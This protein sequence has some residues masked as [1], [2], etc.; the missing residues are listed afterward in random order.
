[1]KKA[2][3]TGRQIVAAIF[4]GIFGHVLFAIGWIGLGLLILGSIL[5]AVLGGSIEALLGSFLDP[6]TIGETFNSAGGV[7]SS[8]AIGL[9]IGAGVFILLGFFV[10]ALILRGG[11]VRRPW[12][13]TLSAILIAAIID[14]PLLFVYASI[15]SGQDSP[16]FLV[17]TVLGTIIVGILVWLW[18]TW[19]HRGP[20][21]EFAG[22][23]VTGTASA[24]PVE[25]GATP[26]A[27]EAADPAPVSAPAVEAEPQ[28]VA[29]TKPRKTPAKPE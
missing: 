26:A 14:V 13:T 6:A 19:G 7:V 1:M 2:T 5:V 20:A 3:L 28:P 16:G 29:V 21:S 23:T 4:A 18:M 27:V 22:T 25:S 24:T 12:A 9:G 8:V 10:S 11:R 15:G 17:V